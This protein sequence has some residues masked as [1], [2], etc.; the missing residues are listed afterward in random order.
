MRQTRSERLWTRFLNHLNTKAVSSSKT[1]KQRSTWWPRLH[2]P[3]FRKKCNKN[4]MIHPRH[5]ADWNLMNFVSR[6]WLNLFRWTETWITIKYV[7]FDAIW[8]DNGFHVLIFVMMASNPL[9]C[10][11]IYGF[12]TSLFIHLAVALPT[13][14]QQHRICIQLSET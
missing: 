13:V 2:L 3:N 1:M 6:N 5:R 7:T 9:R 14:C 12:C 8:N 10:V 11:A 4:Q